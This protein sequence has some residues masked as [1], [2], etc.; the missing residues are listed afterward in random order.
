M[1]YF[2]KIYRFFRQKLRKTLEKYLIKIQ[3]QQ[4]IELNKIKNN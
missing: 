1:S 4:K 3:L 2:Y